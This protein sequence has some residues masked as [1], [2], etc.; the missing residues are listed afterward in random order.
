M[1]YTIVGTPRSR[2]FRVIWMLEEL[3]QPYSI[4]PVAPAS[5]EAKA[6]HPSGKIPALLVE[7][8]VLMDSMAICNFLADRHGGCTH[9]PGSPERSEQDALTYTTIDE[10]E[11]PLWTHAKHS[12]ALPEALRVEAAKTHL[13]GEFRRGLESL[14]QRLGDGTY[15]MGADFTVPDILLGHCGMWAKG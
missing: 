11:S 14:E 3:G 10:I 2:A 6:V 15:L 12:F 13:E 9:P 8:S 4:D 5:P 7:G 1:S